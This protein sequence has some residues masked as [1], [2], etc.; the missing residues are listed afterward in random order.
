MSNP[1]KSVTWSRAES[2]YKSDRTY[3]EVAI[4]PSNEASVQISQSG[5]N[6]GSIT[7]SVASTRELVS[8]LNHLLN[9][10]Q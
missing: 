2:G 10:P 6:V 1:A 3:Y 9:L 4:T 8:A 7:L 5:G